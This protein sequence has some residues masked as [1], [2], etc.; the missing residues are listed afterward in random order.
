[1]FKKFNSKYSA[2][3]QPYAW[4]FLAPALSIITVFNIYPMLRSM[5]LSFQK[6]S[7]F[8]PSFTG[9]NNYLTVLKDPIFHTALKNTAIYAFFVVP[10]CLIISLAIAWLI[11]EKIKYKS[12]FETLFFIPYVT[13]TIAIGI[14]FKYLLNSRYGMVNQL[15]GLFGIE[16]I[17]WLSSIDMSMPSLILFGVWSGLAFNIIILLAGL[18]NINNEYYKVAD[19]FGATNWEKFKRITIPQLLPT[20]TFLM[21]VNFISAFKVYSQVF[22][23]FG[24]QAGIA[25]SAQ[26]A[27]FY[28]YDKFHIAQRPGVAM[29]ATMILFGLIMLFTLIQ[30]KLVAKVEN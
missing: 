2:E 22:A 5:W 20:I 8:N 21:T 9:I 29:A 19:M 17:N 12:F 7:L 16:P 25:N 27:V 30:N 10:I 13:S 18:R 24:G 11:F 23:L 6:G 3:N 26:T 1:M 4:L 15:L 28:I 14:V